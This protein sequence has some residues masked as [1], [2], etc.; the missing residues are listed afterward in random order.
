MQC[1][2]EKIKRKKDILKKEENY[3]SPSICWRS[4]R[5][6]HFNPQTNHEVDKYLLSL[7]L[8]HKVR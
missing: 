8:G 3:Y 1:T 6:P 5:L 7:R 2:T 4:Y